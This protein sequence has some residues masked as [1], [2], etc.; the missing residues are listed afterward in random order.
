MVSAGYNDDGNQP[1]EA[2]FTTGAP[3]PSGSDVS[4]RWL[5]GRTFFDAVGNYNLLVTQESGGLTAS[6]N[7]INLEDA[8]FELDTDSLNQGK[9]GTLRMISADT[10]LSGY[11]SQCTL[12][13]N[14]SVVDQHFRIRR[15]TM[16]YRPIGRMR[17]A[18]SGVS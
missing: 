13:Y 9:L 14:N 6:T 15:S 7:T 8:G 11:D 5:Y 4:L 10:D 17:R 1:I 16:V 18:K 12:N 2:N 3:A